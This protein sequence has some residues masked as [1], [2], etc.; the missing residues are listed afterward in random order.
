MLRSS[1]AA[2]TSATIDDLS[3]SVLESETGHAAHHT[4]LTSIGLIVLSTISSAAA[5]ILLGIGAEALGEAGLAGILTNFPL[6]GGYACLGMN[7]VLV[8]VALR[9]GQLSVLYPIMALSYVWVTILS[10]VYFNDVIS[11]S[12][13]AGLTLIVAGVAFIGSGSR[14]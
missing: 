4:S 12:Q 11:T 3:D 14:S 7:V 9:G 13:I 8:V 6:I 5:Q 2:P 1:F 10:P